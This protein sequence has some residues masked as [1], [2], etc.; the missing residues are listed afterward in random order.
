MIYDVT[1]P[2]KIYIDVF[3][4]NKPFTV[5]SHRNHRRKIVIAKS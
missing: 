5:A 2:F 4:N 3:L 1:P